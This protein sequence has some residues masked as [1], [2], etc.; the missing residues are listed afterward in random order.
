MFTTM[1]NAPKTA[2]QVRAQKFFY[3]AIAGAALSIIGPYLEFAKA[4]NG[5]QSVTMKGNDVGGVG[6][7]PVI[8]GILAIGLL[9]V[10]TRTATLSSRALELGAGVIAIWS[11]IY[12]WVRLSDVKEKINAAQFNTVTITGQIGFW[13]IT[14]GG[15]LLA[16]VALTMAW[17]EFSAGRTTMTGAPMSPYGMPVPPGYPTAPSGQQ[18]FPVQ[19][20]PMPSQMPSQVPP[21]V[22]Q[23]QQQVPAYPQQYPPQYA[24][25]E[26]PQYGQQYPAQ[27]V[28]PAQPQ[29]PPQYPPQNGTPPQQ[30]G[31]SPL[32]PAA[33]TYG[34]RR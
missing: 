25:P 13:A 6:G 8:F 33:P 32:P 14:I 31:P 28:P 7:W 5:Y 18:A 22:P 15:V 21:Q 3:V 16:V 12:P 11:A 17:L 23:Y 20:P 4:T 2:A 27:Y 26:Q 34:G 30:P 10:A 24:Q 19:P 9:F 1:R 29:Y